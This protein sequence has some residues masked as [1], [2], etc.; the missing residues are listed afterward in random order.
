MM[1]ELARRWK[2]ALVDFAA[3]RHTT[4]SETVRDALLQTYEQLLLRRAHDDAQR[5]A[6]A[7]DDKA[8]MLAIELFMGAA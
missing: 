8:E 5:L 1:Q 2:K 7:P 6:N 3:V 4:R